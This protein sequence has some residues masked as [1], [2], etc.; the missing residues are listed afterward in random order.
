MVDSKYYKNLYKEKADEE[1]RYQK[2]YKELKKIYT[3]LVD[4]QD[5]EINRLNSSLSSLKDT[6]SNAVRHNYQM[7]GIVRTVSA[8]HE[9]DPYY[10]K[11]LSVAIYAIDDELKQIRNK[12]T[13]AKKAKEDYQKKYKEK[14]DQE[15]REFWENVWK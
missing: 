15:N 2:N 9:N 6:L 10:E 11:R 8:R 4:Q 14:K 1:E 13:V 5:D 7:D 3:N 12:Q